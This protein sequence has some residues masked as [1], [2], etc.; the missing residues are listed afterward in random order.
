V[1]HASSPVEAFPLHRHFSQSVAVGSSA[2]MKICW[3]RMLY[4]GFFRRGLIRSSSFA[5]PP[6]I[7]IRGLC[8]FSI[9]LTRIIA[10]YFCSHSTLF[11]HLVCEPSMAARFFLKVFS[12]SSS[13]LSFG[14]RTF[15]VRSGFQRLLF[16]HLLNRITVPMP[17]CCLRVFV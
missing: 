5:L 17:L 8:P 16:P 3:S 1:P 14:S 15:C 2:L 4:S 10:G 11:P 7:L 12:F 13:F 9:E 6:P